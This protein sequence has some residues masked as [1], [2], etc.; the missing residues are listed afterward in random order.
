MA[1][2][3]TK[4]KRSKKKKQEKKTLLNNMKLI[5]KI[6]KRKLGFTNKL[7]VSIMILLFMGLILGYDLAVKSIHYQYTGALACYTAVFCPLGTACS[8]VLAKVVNK[9]K[10]ENTGSDGMGIT[11]AAAQAN[12][13]KSDADELFENSPSI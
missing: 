9:N 3:S 4:N 13:F 7:A 11:F 10:E 1:N 8:I 12:N 2:R 6:R 5:K